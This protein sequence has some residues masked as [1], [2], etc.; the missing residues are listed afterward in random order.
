MP[1]TKVEWKLDS[2][3]VHFAT[4]YKLQEISTIFFLGRTYQKS[5]CVATY[6]NESYV[7]ISTT[8]AEK[9]DSD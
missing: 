5:L 1:L 3:V 4:M 8:M 7:R 2:A 6:R 9:G